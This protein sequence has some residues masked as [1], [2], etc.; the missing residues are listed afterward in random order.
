MVNVVLLVTWFGECG[1]IGDISVAL[2]ET[3]FDQFKLGVGLGLELFQL[4]K[5]LGREKLPSLFTQDQQKPQN[6]HQ[7]WLIIDVR[8][9]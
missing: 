8:H 3:N 5:L 1:I 4:M 2:T 7:D 6:H 9:I